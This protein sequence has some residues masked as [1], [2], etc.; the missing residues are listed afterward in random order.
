MRQWL[1]G[2]RVY[3][4]NEHRTILW[5]WG[6]CS[7]LVISCWVCNVLPFTNGSVATTGHIIGVKCGSKGFG[8]S[9]NYEAG[10]FLYGGS[11]GWGGI[12]GNGPC[13]SLHAGSPV[14]ITYRMSEPSM[15]M[16]GTVHAWNKALAFFLTYLAAILLFILPVINYAKE[17]RK[18]AAKR[19]VTQAN[20]QT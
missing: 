13:S 12:D 6:I 19:G 10:N 16:G 11:S 8:Y 18:D 2:F 9:Y 15:S 20:G 7:F 17:R 5:M 1:L 4:Q 3:Y 14:T